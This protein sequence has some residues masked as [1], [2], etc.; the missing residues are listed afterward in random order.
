MQTTRHPTGRQLRARIQAY[1]AGNSNELIKVLIDA[2]LENDEDGA[3]LESV[4]TVA[5][6]VLA[7]ITGVEAAEQDAGVA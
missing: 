7:P 6:I 3:K 4:A 2:M 1:L 5:R